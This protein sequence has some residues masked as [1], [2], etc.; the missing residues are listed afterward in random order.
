MRCRTCA[1]ALCTGE[2]DA[3]VFIVAHPNL[4]VEDM[5][6]TC[7][8]VLVP[9]A[10]PEIERLM[11]ANPYYTPSEIASG[12]YGGQAIGVPTFALTATLV[13]SSRTSPAVV[14]ALTKAVF[15]NFDAFRAAH[16]A[17]GA[18]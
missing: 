7:N 17:F 14:Y 12:T 16:P 8:A 3:A 5:I 4:T 13:T 9:V 11:A 2:I 6:S 18:I 1:R 15:E 10:G